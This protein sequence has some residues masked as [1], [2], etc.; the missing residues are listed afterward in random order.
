[1]S[2]VGQGALAKAMD[3]ARKCE[4]AAKVVALLVPLATIA[5]QHQAQAGV[6]CPGGA[7]QCGGKGFDLPNSGGLNSG[8]TSS[9][10][11]NWQVYQDTTVC[12]PARLNETCGGTFY[13]Y[14]YQVSM[15][16]GAINEIDIPMSFDEVFSSNVSSGYGTSFS[17][18]EFRIFSEGAPQDELDITL[19]SV[20]G[21]T[22]VNFGF[23]TTIGDNTNNGPVDPPAPGR[24]AVP[25]P[26]TPCP[27]SA[28]PSSASRAGGAD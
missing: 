15:S 20:F 4:R 9:G 28:W 24:G 16:S 17:S 7:I 13:E 12:A 2:E 14:D 19:D 8:Q 11:I 23:D 22:D 6:S 5:A 18:G 25:E 10:F 3:V 1:M 21:P 26:G 27:S